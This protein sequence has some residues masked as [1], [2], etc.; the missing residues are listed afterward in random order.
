MLLSKGVEH[1]GYSGIVY[2]FFCR[3]GIV[4]FV[5][6]VF[7][8]LLMSDI[9]GG[10]PV[11]FHLIP[12]L[13]EI[14]LQVAMFLIGIPL[15]D[16]FFQRTETVPTDALLLQ[17]IMA[18]QILPVVHVIEADRMRNI[19]RPGLFFLLHTA[20]SSVFNVVTSSTPLT[21]GKQSMIY[22]RC[23]AKASSG[24]KF[25]SFPYSFSTP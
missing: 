16:L 6:Q 1:I 3:I 11:R 9:F 10:F 21:G 18:V 7:Y 14:P 8:L 24:W 2:Q 22:D 13:R 15:Q 25:T 19:V 12:Y 17:I 5:K 23:P 20:S 4:P